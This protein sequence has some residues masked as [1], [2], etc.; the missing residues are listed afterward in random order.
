MKV[1][2]GN[3]GHVLPYCSMCLYCFKGNLILQHFL[4][5]HYYLLLSSPH[6]DAHTLTG[7]G[8]GMRPMLSPAA[9]AASLLTRHSGL[10]SESFFFDSE[11]SS[12]SSLEMTIHLGGGTCPTPGVADRELV[13]EEL[14][15]EPERLL[16]PLTC[17]TR[18]VDHHNQTYPLNKN[19]IWA[20]I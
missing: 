19:S 15:L 7:G 3:V 17:T 4:L 5:H 12:L 13:K 8:L 2:Q 18:E 16:F 9:I 10:Y 14:R 1:L 20:S 6:I 11:E